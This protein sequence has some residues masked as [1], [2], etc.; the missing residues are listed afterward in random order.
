MALN[1]ISFLVTPYL[2][3]PKEDNKSGEVGNFRRFCDI[4]C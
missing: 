2:K 1:A 3:I 4:Y